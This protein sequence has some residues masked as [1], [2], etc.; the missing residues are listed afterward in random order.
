MKWLAIK[1]K[2]GS[3][4]RYAMAYATHTVALVF[5][6][7]EARY[8]VWRLGEPAVRL[9]DFKTSAEA[10]MACEQDTKQGRVAA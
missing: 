4:D 8:E 6:H 7:A 10:Q 3:V 2:D 9:G 5:V 1:R